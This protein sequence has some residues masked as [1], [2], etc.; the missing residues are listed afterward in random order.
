MLLATI[1]AAQADIRRVGCAKH[2]G[3]VWAVVSTDRRN[4][5]PKL[6]HWGLVLQDLAWAFV[7]LPRDY[8]EVC[9]GD[10][11]QRSFANTAWANTGWQNEHPCPCCRWCILYPSGKIYSA[12]GEGGENPALRFKYLRQ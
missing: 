4:T 10:R 9:L 11:L 7:Q 5:L 2:E 6:R 3:P 8:T 1:G 12:T